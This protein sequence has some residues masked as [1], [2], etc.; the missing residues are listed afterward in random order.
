MTPV[1]EVPKPV[2]VTVRR[3]PPALPEAGE[4]ETRVGTAVTVEIVA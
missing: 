3:V 1:V 4:M 2:P